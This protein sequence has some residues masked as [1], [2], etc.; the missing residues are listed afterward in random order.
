M[1]SFL[2]AYPSFRYK[3]DVISYTD[4]ILQKLDRIQNPKMKPRSRPKS[5]KKKEKKAEVD[6]EGV[7]LNG[8][9]PFNA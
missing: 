2:D 6:L 9:S 7:D 5:S 4:E 8:M 3:N 1:I